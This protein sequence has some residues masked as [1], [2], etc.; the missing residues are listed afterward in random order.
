MIL[1]PQQQKNKLNQLHHLNANDNAT[2]KKKS[3]EEEALPP[4][5][6]LQSTTPPPNLHNTTPTHAV[7]PKPP[8]HLLPECNMDSSQALPWKRKLPPCLYLYDLFTKA[9]KKNS[10]LSS[11]SHIIETLKIVTCHLSLKAAGCALS[12]SYFQVDFLA[13]FSCWL[14]LELF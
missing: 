4:K 14:R 13:Q 3:S 5:I 12:L 6:H 1:T 2:T 10:P 11:S 7:P 9:N 8:S